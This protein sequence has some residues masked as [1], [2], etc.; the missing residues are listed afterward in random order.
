MKSTDCK[1]GEKMEKQD[2][3]KAAESYIAQSPDNY[4]SEEI[5][6]S[7]SSVGLKIYDA[8]IFA[9]GSADDEYFQ[10]LKNPAAIGE[11]YMLPKDWLPTAK[12]VVSFFLPFSEAV[13]V[14]NRKSMSWPSDEWLHGRIEGQML[15]NK[16]CGHL[17]S[18]LV[19]SGYQSV[20]P[21]LDERFRS[22]ST[23]DGRVPD[24]TSNWSERH[25]A[26]ICG[27]GTFGLSRGL[28][29]KKGIAGRFGSVITELSLAPDARE[30][31]DL[32]EYCSLCGNCVRNCPAGAISKE[33]GKKHKPCS[34]FLDETKKKH[35][36]RYGC[37]KCQ[38]HVP[39]ESRIPVHQ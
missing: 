11:H 7:K 17:K 6:I 15:L 14:S 10:R 21:S 38:V 2:L 32:Y 35:N 26:F 28:I 20:V 33:T 5:A 30:Y 8:P 31:E 16:L 24:F 39:C 25:A 12:T 19:A 36:P 3:I 34:D 22:V 29:T 23:G 37:G 27:L 18:L 13:R 9:F 4:I 1:G